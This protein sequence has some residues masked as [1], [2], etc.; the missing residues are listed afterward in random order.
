MIQSIKD[1]KSLFE[2][3]LEG[4]VN[5]LLAPVSGKDERQQLPR[6][7]FNR[8]PA[9][10]IAKLS[11]ALALVIIS[12]ITIL[13]KP[14]W[15]LILLA[16]IVNGLMYA[17]LVELQHECLHGHAFLSPKLN[18]F[19]GIICG[20]FMMNS[21]SHYRYDHLRHH[22][23]LGSFRNKEHF[24]YR[25]QNLNSLLGLTLSF[26]DLSRY[27]RIAHFT[28][29]TIFWRPLPGIE[30]ENYNRNIKQEYL[31]NFMLLVAS[32]VLTVYTGTSIFILAWWVPSL[33][34]AEG[35]HFMIEM[36]EHFGLNTQTDANVLSN[37]RTINTSRLMSWFVNGNNIHTAHHYHQGVPMC[38]VQALHKLIEPKIMVVEP[39]YRY[40]Y[41]QVFRGR[42]QQNV[43]ET[44]MER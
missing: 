14:F 26:F 23:Y 32:I 20:I 7:L 16:M 13:F 21:Y 19:F 17:H 18:R 44:C 9:I 27:K 36:P 5:V 30:K 37:T 40:F 29:L 43:D 39:S 12:W 3:N 1:Q 6:E 28:L 4:D 33:L 24:D 31:F 34:L 15:S 42:I 25:F 38:N 35:V 8:K 10:F 11:F 41:D 2:D 22:A